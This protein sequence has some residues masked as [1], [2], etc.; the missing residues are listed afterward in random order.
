MTRSALTVK[1]FQKNVRN[2]TYLNKSVGVSRESD[3]QITLSINPWSTNLFW[4]KKKIRIEKY[5]F[6]LEKN[7]FEFFYHRKILTFLGFS[8]EKLIFSLKNMIFSLKK[9]QWKNRFLYWKNQ[10]FQFFSMIKNFKI[11]FLQEKIIIFDTD[12]FP[13]SE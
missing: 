10:N 7:D 11:I 9:C 2:C 13:V 3:S 8:I 1:L 6:F 4:G 12:F 5:Y